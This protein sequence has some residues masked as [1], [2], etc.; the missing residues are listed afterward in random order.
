M[1]FTA[2]EWAVAIL[3]AVVLVLCA[4]FALVTIIVAAS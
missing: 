2:R 3:G 1:G 4:W